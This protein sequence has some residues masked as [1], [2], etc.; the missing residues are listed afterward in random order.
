MMANVSYKAIKK[1]KVI[2]DK[3]HHNPGQTQSL[4][5]KNQQT[6]KKCFYQNRPKNLLL[7]LIDHNVTNNKTKQKKL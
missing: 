2:I 5:Q 7:Y 4:K 6:V 1:S 3:H